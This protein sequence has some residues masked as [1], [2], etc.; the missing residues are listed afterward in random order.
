MNP[1]S[2]GRDASRG[3]QAAREEKAESSVENPVNMPACWKQGGR[4][5]RC[6][7]RPVPAV[8]L[9][10]QSPYR[11]VPH[12]S[13]TS[14]RNQSRPSRSCVRTL[15]R[16]WPCATPLF[17]ILAHEYFRWTGETSGLLHELKEPLKAATNW[18]GLSTLRMIDLSAQSVPRV[19]AKGRRLLAGQQACA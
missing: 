18:Y 5:G 12:L 6:A 3:H 16:G 10:R 13:R 9:P 14:P 19:F 8:A 7:C 17:L 2:D 15:P 11:C 4:N 1:W